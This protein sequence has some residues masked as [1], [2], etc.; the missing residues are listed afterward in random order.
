MRGSKKDVEKTM[1]KAFTQAVKAGGRVR[2]VHVSKTR[3]RKIVFD[4]K[5]KSHAGHTFTCK[6]KGGVGKKRR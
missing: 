6:P 5:G 3:C 4:S 2:T 1:P